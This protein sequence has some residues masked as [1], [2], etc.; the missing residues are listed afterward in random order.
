[1]IETKE[2]KKERKRIKDLVESSLTNAKAKGRIRIGT[3]RLDHLIKCINFNIDNPNYVR[4]ELR[5]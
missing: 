3:T 5:S 1:M 2:I 4:K